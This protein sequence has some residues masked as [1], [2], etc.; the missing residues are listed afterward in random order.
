MP[1]NEQRIR[2]AIELNALHSTG[3]F[4][5]TL[6]GARIGS[7]TPIFDLNGTQLYERIPLTSGRVEGY[8][9][10]AVHPAIGGVLMAVSHGL[11]W[12]GSALLEQ[13]REHLPPGG[14]PPDA[15]RF[16]AYSY[17]KLAVQFLAR[18]EEQ[19]LLELYSWLPVP[20]HRER[21]PGEPPS[22]FDRWSFLD[23]QPREVLDRRRERFAARVR[24]IESVPN[25]DRIALDRIALK[26]FVDLV[27][28]APLGGIGKAGGPG[29][30][31]AVAGKAAGGGAAGGKA[32]GGGAAGGKAAGGG[33][34][35]GSGTDAGGGAGG[36]G[37]PS[38]Q[39]E[40]H[41]S[42]RSSDHA[43]CY[44][45]QGQATPVW[46]VAAS[47]QMLLDFYRYEYTQDRVAKALGLGT[48][49][50]P[51]ELASGNEGKVVKVLRDLTANAL[52]AT[53]VKDPTWDDFR[54]EIVANRP[55][56]S[57]VPSHARTVAGYLDTGPVTAQLGPFQ[58][59]LVYDPWP[60][61]M[62]VVTRW[63]NFDVQIYEFAFLARLHLA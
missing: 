50:K 54:D 31:G 25:R 35:D 13:S 46:C 61:D 55:L 52:D 41:F 29:R 27:G 62:G 57:F 40:L 60:P 21:A 14:K 36:P 5:D 30:G 6:E 43:T 12:D 28:V 63:E 4:G 32:A 11:A 7:G 49:G 59:L 23:D 16:V 3:A 20:P 10:V 15:S 38:S 48:R 24:G 53:M 19:A 58:G 45:V 8:A 22:Y 44:E 17:P 47:V 42:T 9:D 37:G 2:V 1:G 18:G 51:K 34:A 26:H 33:A 56:I 39:R